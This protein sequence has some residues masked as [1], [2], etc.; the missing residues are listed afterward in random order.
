MDMGTA[1]VGPASRRKVTP[2]H[3]TISS[4]PPVLYCTGN[5]GAASGGQEERG[6]L[7]ER[8]AAVLVEARNRKSQKLRERELCRF[9]GALHL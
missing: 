9:V 1:G 8:L 5:G 2:G 3:I 6:L 7:L 4:Y